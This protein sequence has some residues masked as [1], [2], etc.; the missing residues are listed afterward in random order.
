MACSGE[1]TLPG[2]S[3]ERMRRIHPKNMRN[4]LIIRYVAHFLFLI[5]IDGWLLTLVASWAN[6]C[7]EKD[8]RLS[9]AEKYEEAARIDS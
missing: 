4:Y 6:Q 3:V 8:R 9:K 2:F 7:D 5:F 1:Q